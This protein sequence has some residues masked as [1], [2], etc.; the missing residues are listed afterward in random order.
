MQMPGKFEG[1]RR[2]TREYAARQVDNGSHHSSPSSTP[3]TTAGP[4]LWTLTP[5]RELVPLAGFEPTASRLVTPKRFGRATCAMRQQGDRAVLVHMPRK[6]VTAVAATRTV[7]HA[8]AIT[9]IC[10]DREGDCRYKAAPTSLPG[11][12]AQGTISSP[13]TSKASPCRWP[14]SI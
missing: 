7:C 12:G 11:I 2:S 5:T 1:G 3:S 10:A 13:A 6:G 8:E 4:Y 9:G 14:I